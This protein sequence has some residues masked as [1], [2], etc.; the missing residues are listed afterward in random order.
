MFALP[1]AGDFHAEHDIAGHRRVHDA[2]VLSC[3]RSIS[4]FSCCV[5]SEIEARRGWRGPDGVGIAIPGENDVPA[6][7]VDA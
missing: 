7:A 6:V 3:A 1:A 5:P 2:A 4:T